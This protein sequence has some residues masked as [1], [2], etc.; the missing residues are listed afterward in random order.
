[1]EQISSLATEKNV[2]HFSQTKKGLQF[3]E[4]SAQI[5]SH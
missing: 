4:I 1:M 3:S 2:K 5:S